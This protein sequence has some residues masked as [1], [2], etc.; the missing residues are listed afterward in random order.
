MKYKATLR[1][2]T[3]EQFAF[4]E[5]ETVVGSPEEAEAIY[6]HATALFKPM[7]GGV[8]LDTKDWNRIVDDYIT[9]GTMPSDAGEIMNE[10]QRWFIHE[11]DK[12]TNRVKAK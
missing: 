1:V 5:L 3:N 4:I 8:G 11:L 6:N 7:V 9:V 2:P 10:R 12:S